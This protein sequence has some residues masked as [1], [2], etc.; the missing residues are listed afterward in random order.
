MVFLNRTAPQ[1]VK[2]EAITKTVAPPA[3][4]L[5]LRALLSTSTTITG[6]SN[7][8]VPQNFAPKAAH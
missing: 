4:E 6:S 7:F 1:N 5:K 3:D 2:V 8:K